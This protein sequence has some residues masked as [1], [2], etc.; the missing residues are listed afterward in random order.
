MK[1]ADIPSEVFTL[2]ARI[3]QRSKDADRSYFKAALENGADYAALRRQ[4]C[5]F[6]EKEYID[7]CIINTHKS[8]DY[9]R[10]SMRIYEVFKPLLESRP[11]FESY[12]VAKSFQCI[13]YIEEVEPEGRE[14]VIEATR[15]LSPS[16][17]V[18]YF[19]E[20]KGEVIE[21]C[22]CQEF[23]EVPIKVCKKCGKEK[24]ENKRRQKNKK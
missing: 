11:D 24:K 15:P 14:E 21:D 17:A 1:E 5:W 7:N 23:E 16:D 13:Q 22:I 4:K 8:A 20:R 12:G 19:K 6:N 3:N 10:K 9:V 2:F 18:K